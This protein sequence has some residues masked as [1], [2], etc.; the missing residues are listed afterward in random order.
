MQ[1]K[2]RAP[3]ISP[4][5]RHCQAGY[6]LVTTALTL[7]TLLGFLGFLVDVGFLYSHKREAQIA[8]DAAAQ[9]AVLQM[10]NGA[11]TA[12]A[13]AYA[14]S[15]SALNG[16]TNGS[17][18]VTVTIN[19]PPTS[20]SYMGT[21]GAAEAIVQQTVPTTL[22][23]LLN[24]SSGSIK[25]RGVAYRGGS[26]GC[27]YALDATASDAF[28]ASGS[29]D[30]NTNCG[31][32]VNSS[33]SKAL[34]VSGSACIAT[35]TVIS[36]VGNYSNSSS[37]T[38]SPTPKTGQKAAA[39]PLA[40]VAA[41]TVPAGCNSTSYKLSSGSATISPGTYCGGITVSSSATL[42]LNSGLY[43]LKGGGLTVSG[44]ASIISNT[45]GVTFYNTQASS[46]AYKPVVISGGSSTNLQAPT[47]TA[48]G[49]IYGVLI[50]QDRSISSSSQNTVSGGSGAVFTGALYF[51]T[52]PLVYSGG[53]TGSG[54]WTALIADTLT[55]SGDSSLGNDFSSYPGGSP[56]L[57]TGSTFGE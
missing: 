35:P 42:Y 47:S 31:L 8:A 48:T 23:K 49:G 34:S 13:I 24:I 21:P 46:Y 27:I 15:D 32:Y 10:A 39:D 57:G 3:R 56:I 53:S 29:A 43:F 25:A 12:N 11:T 22:L 40:Y 26:G 19:I 14:K 45:G 38:L 17:N 16:F 44:G 7:A 41:P 50:F 55:F 4:S 37:C 2:N 28:V 36:I 6:V 9:E 51:P 18:G 52:T 54:E 20:G 1:D 33:S 30:V 5:L